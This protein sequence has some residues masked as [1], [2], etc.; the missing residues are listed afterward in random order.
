MRT[1]LFCL[2]SFEMKGDGQWWAARERQPGQGLCVPR[3]QR[4]AWGGK[5]K[6]KESERTRKRKSRRSPAAGRKKAWKREKVELENQIGFRMV[7]REG[8][9]FGEVQRL[10]KSSFSLSC[11]SKS[12][13]H[14]LVR[15]LI[16]W[17]QLFCNSAWGAESG[18]ERSLEPGGKARR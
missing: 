13:P 7:A 9:S 17:E 11:W 4:E 8:G 3:E 12:W 2:R 15:N 5:P 18:E 6:G 16:T 14:Q 10:A 1:K